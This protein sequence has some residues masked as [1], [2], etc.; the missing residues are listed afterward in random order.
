MPKDNTFLFVSTNFDEA[1]EAMDRALRRLN[2][3]YQDKKLM[4]YGIFPC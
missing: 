3:E 2:G 4:V 1:T